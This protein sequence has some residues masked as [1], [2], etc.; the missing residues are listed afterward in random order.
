M[1]TTELNT[2]NEIR[3]MSDQDLDAVAGGFVTYHGGGGGKVI[4]SGN[5]VQEGVLAS[6][7]VV[8]GF[9]LGGAIFGL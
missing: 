5:F 1:N 8:A 2:A 7:G 3:A 4:G 6:I 9:V